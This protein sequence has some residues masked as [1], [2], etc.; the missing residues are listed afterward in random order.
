VHYACGSGVGNAT[1]SST[2]NAS[3][4]EADMQEVIRA[5]AWCN[6]EV[7]YLAWERRSRNSAVIPDGRRK[8]DRQ[9]L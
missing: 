5:G 9:P 3:L 7:A 2:L 8:L 4:R 1:M 6:G